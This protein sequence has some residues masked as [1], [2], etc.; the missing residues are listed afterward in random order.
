M[1]RLF[2]RIIEQRTYVEQ[3]QGFKVYQEETFVCR[4]KK[5]T[6]WRTSNAQQKRGEKPSITEILYQNGYSELKDDGLPI[7]DKALMMAEE[8]PLGYVPV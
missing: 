6:W 7:H 8:V 3:P 2:S 4:W 1:Q 5:T